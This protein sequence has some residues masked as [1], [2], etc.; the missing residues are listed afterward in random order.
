MNSLQMEAPLLEE[1]EA[2]IRLLGNIPE[3]VG[4]TGRDRNIW[5]LAVYRDKLY[6]GYGNT[7]TNPG[8]LDLYSYDLITDEWHN[9]INIKTEAIER[10]RIQDQQIYIP[11]SDPRLSDERKF[12]TLENDEWEEYLLMPEMAHVRDIYS[13]NDHLYMLGN[14]R[15]PS[16]KTIEC[17]GLIRLDI[18]SSLV[19]SD[20]LHTALSQAGDFANG[21]WNWFFG[22]F[23]YKNLLI[24]PNAMFTKG[25]HTNLEIDNNMFYTID[26]FWHR[27]LVCLPEEPN[28][29]KHEYFFP[30]QLPNAQDSSG[31]LI[32]L[33][34]L[35]KY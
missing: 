28:Q 32:S 18:E 23:E 33:E 16:Q 21:R 10:I 27:K 15:C 35:R 29:L 5:D 25:A 8:P 9:E 2:K 1:K 26:H 20:L 14:T 7:T 13:F 31:V 34:T 3:E 22:L 11:N 4:L 24:I 30:P 19:E 6:L 17:S 12:W